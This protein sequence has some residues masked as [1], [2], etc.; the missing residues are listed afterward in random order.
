M[1]AQA[2]GSKSAQIPTMHVHLPT[3]WLVRRTERM[4][5]L[6]ASAVGVVG[7]AHTFVTA[8]GRSRRA[9]H[10]TNRKWSDRRPNGS[11]FLLSRC[12]SGYK[13]VLH[14]DTAVYRTVQMCLVKHMSEF[15]DPYP[16]F[17]LIC[18]AISLC[19]TLLSPPHTI[20]MMLHWIVVALAL[21]QVQITFS[22]PCSSLLGELT[23]G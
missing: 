14:R 23:F 4:P 16:A 5:K 8:V 3:E 10:G 11:C 13:H 1:N 2:C 21:T 12:C 6:P 9:R 18:T 15:E 19:S 22:S 17:N 7:V 20:T